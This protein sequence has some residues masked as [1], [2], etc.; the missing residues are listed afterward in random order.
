MK[1]IY[2]KARRVVVWL[3]PG[4]KNSDLAMMAI[5]FLSVRSQE[6]ELLRDTYQ[7]VDHYIIRIPC[8]QWRREH[9]KLRMRKAVLRAIYHLLTRSYWCRLWIF[10]KSLW[11]RDNRLSYVGTVA[12]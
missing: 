8:F 2:A 9:V 10:K 12:S 11:Q 7:K 1:D 4:A 3:G 5:L 6:K